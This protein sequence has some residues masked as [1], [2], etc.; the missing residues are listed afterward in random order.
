MMTERGGCSA[1]VL[2]SCRRSSLCRQFEYHPSQPLM[3]VGTVE[4]DVVVLDWERNRTL[5]RVKMPDSPEQNA[6]VL[7]LAWLRQSPDRLLAAAANGYAAMFRIDPSKVLCD[8]ELAEQQEAL[9]LAAHTA[10][11]AASP[12]KPASHECLSLVTS[13]SKQLAPKL[14]SM[15]CNSSDT[16]M[17][18]SGY[19]HDGYVADLQTGQR[20]RKLKSIHNGHINVSATHRDRQTALIRSQ[21]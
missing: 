12:A 5:G 15:H 4:S 19:T 6:V 14:T 20:L 9:E 7:A 1:K 13:Y 11:A 18:G 2:T 21:C 17:A 16:L 8:D 10:A 3:A